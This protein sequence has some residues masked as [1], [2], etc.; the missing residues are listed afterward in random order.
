V[1]DELIPF[2]SVQALQADWCRAGGHVTLYP[3][4]LSEHSSLA[5][6]G[7]PLAVGFLTSRFAGVDVPATCG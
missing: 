3:D 4:V 5:V 6:S 2:A 7:A 1:N